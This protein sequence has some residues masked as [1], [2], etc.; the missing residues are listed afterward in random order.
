[1]IIHCKPAMLTVLLFVYTYDTV[2]FRLHLFKQFLNIDRVIYVSPSL[3][4]VISFLFGK[5]LIIISFFLAALLYFVQS[6]HFLTQ[7][8]S[9]PSYL[10]HSFF[11]LFFFLS[12]VSS[13]ESVYFC[14]SNETW[15]MTKYHHTDCLRRMCIQSLVNTFTQD[16]NNSNES[17]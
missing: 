8:L 11:S 10:L 3:C 14:V 7:S 2:Y 9:L 6:I 1:M 12:F 4:L 13:I 17:N 5:F 15:L 16:K